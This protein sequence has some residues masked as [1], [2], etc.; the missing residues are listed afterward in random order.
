MCVGFCDNKTEKVQILNT[1]EIELFLKNE[2]RQTVVPLNYSIPYDHTFW[3][4]QF[5]CST[6][7]MGENLISKY[8]L[9][10]FH[11]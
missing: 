1:K 7:L 10:G 4:E 11:I 2:R 6:Y 9:F 5:V 8:H 3:F